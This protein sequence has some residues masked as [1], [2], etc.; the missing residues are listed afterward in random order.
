MKIVNY[1]RGVTTLLVP[2]EEMRPANPPDITTAINAIKAHYGFGWAPDLNRTYDE[3]QKGPHTFSGGKLERDGKVISITK[4]QFFNDGIVVT[5]HSTENADAIIEDLI[6]WGTKT[7]GYRPFQT[8]PTRLHN[9]AIAIDMDFDL[10]HILGP[11][12]E[13]SRL[14]AEYLTP[15]RPKAPV[16]KAATLRFTGIASPK[17]APDMNNVFLIERRVDV[18]HE[19]NRYFSDAPLP[20]Q[21]HV[22]FLEAL[23]KIV[24]GK[25]A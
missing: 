22:R 9:S 19:K 8:V 17:E 3:V 20:T 1:E 4:L 11:H 12:D 15:A 6:E 2:M 25:A 24:A 14:F 13:L 10:D 16:W 5:S 23:E 18:P 21:A 7:F